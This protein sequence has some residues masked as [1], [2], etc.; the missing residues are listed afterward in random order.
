MKPIRAVFNV[1]PQFGKSEL[2]MHFLAWALLKRPVPMLYLGYSAQFITTQMRRARDIAHRAGVPFT[3]DTRAISEWRTMAGAQLYA[4]GI[5]GDVTGRPGKLIIVDDPIRNWVEAQSRQIRNTADETLKSGVLTRAHEDTSI[6]VVA[7]RWHND[8]VCGRLGDRGWKVVNLPAIN[9]LGESLWPGMKSIEF[10]ELQRRDLGPIMFEAMFQGRPRP[11]GSDVFIDATLVDV[12]DIPSYG[13]YAIGVDL[14]Y[15][16][17]TSSDFSAAVVLMESGGRY[18]VREV[19]RAQQSPVDFGVR[20]KGLAARYPGAPVVWHGS[21]TEQGS[22]DF[23][24]REGIPLTFKPARND[25]FVRAQPVS[26]QWN[27]GNVLVPQ[28]APWAARF[29][30]EVTTFTGMGDAHDD[31]VDALA[32]AF[33][34]L[35]NQPKMMPQSLRRMVGAN[36][37]KSY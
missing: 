14:A 27:A 29:I 32:S 2:I 30:D 19:V 18:Y 34:A 5:T 23:L 9:E 1:P 20:L 4:T 16:A 7:T 10:L 11:V 3:P 6:I 36:L 8:D 21:G 35:N 33:D 25:K 24:K 12:N 22:A 31:Q 28:S 37:R 15:T 17:K 13:R 26:A